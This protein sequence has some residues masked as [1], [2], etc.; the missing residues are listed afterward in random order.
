MISCFRD[1]IE[2]LSQK[3]TDATRR[4]GDIKPS[5]HDAKTENLVKGEGISTVITV[6]RSPSPIATGTSALLY[7]N[8]KIVLTRDQIY[9]IFE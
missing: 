6:C 5:A 4:D 9:I 3:L 1:E 7:L 2:N 8:L